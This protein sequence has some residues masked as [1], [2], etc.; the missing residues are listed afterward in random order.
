[1]IGFPEDVEGNNPRQFMADLFKEVAAEAQSNSTPELDRAHC[2]FRP[3]PRHG[4]C[5]VIV[6]FHRYIE[7]VLLRAKK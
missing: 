2:I 5:P 3:K 1:M 4:S 6:R 7:I